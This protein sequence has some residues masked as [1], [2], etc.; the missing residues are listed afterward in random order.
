MRD[1][2]KDAG[3]PETVRPDLNGIQPAIA[4]LSGP[5]EEWLPLWPRRGAPGFRF[6]SVRLLLVDVLL[7]EL[8]SGA[9][10]QKAREA[11]RG[12]G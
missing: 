11:G 8:H 5:G 10:P 2:R 1:R 3:F 7:D 9:P 12:S 6:N 4:A